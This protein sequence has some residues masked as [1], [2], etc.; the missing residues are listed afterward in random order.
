MKKHLAKALLIATCASAIIGC[1]DIITH[2]HAEDVK[3]T[4]R[5]TLIPQGAQTLVKLNG[6]ESRRLITKDDLTQPLQLFILDP[7]LTDLTVIAP[8]DSAIPGVYSFTFTPKSSAGYRVWAYVQPTASI[9]KKQTE[10]FPQ[11]DLGAR[12]PGNITKTESHDA[13]IGGMHFVLSFDKAPTLDDESTGTIRITGKDGNTTTASGEIIGF[14]DDFHSV[15]RLPL[16]DKG[17]FHLTPNKQGF[18]KL[19]ARVKL[20]GKTV[21][22]PFGV[23]VSKPKE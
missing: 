7:T 18:I 22:V 10:E 4:I 12:K 13:T 1:S 3:P 8:Q 17:S 11:A 6:I 14:Y 9:S 23:L 2:H 19:F 16:D 20:D 5:L 15:F 21:S